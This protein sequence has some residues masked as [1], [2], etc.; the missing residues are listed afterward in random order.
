MLEEDE[1]DDDDFPPEEEEGPLSQKG[2]LAS[3]LPFVLTVDEL[4]DLLR[5]NPDT[6]YRL[7]SEG[8]IPGTRK[9][10]GCVRILRDS[11]LE[12]MRGQ[13]RVQ[14]STRK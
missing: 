13:D 5:I 2:V 6:A 14:R 1:M 4:A 11:V 10:G 7:C 3:D 9:V 12:W 8:K